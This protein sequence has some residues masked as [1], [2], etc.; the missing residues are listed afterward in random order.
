MSTVISCNYIL[1]IDPGLERTG[2]AVIDASARRVV[3]AG[4]V[5]TDAKLNLA[6]RLA[7]IHAGLVEVLDEHAVSLM[8]VEDL[9]AHY[10]HPRTAILMGHARGTV[11]LLAAQRGIAVKSL[12]ATLIKKTMTGSGRASKPQ[13]QR[14]MM[15]TLGLRQM[16]E[17]PDVADAMAIGLSAALA[18]REVNTMVTSV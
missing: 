12:P 6:R 5:R 14:A 10:K 3:D 9:Y 13:I 18:M 4:I 11:L 15:A 2:Y 17:P 8:A 16:P 7:D 1:G